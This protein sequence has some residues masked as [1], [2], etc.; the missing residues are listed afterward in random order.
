MDNK[1]AVYTICHNEEDNVLS[2]I[3][4]TKEADIVIV[5][6]TGST[7]NTVALLEEH[8]ITV[9]KITVSPW[10]FDEA[11]NQ[12]LKLLPKDITICIS[13]DFDERLSTGWRK[14]IE[15]VWRNE[16]TRLNYNYSET[17]TINS[18]RISTIISSRIHSR[19]N[20]QWV[21]PVHELL[22]YQGPDQEVMNYVSGLEIIHTPE[23]S[24]DRSQ[25]LHLMKLAVA[26]HPKDLRLVHQLGRD[27]MQYGWYDQCIETMKYNL[28]LEAVSNEQ[29]N[30]CRRLIARAYG[31][32]KQVEKAKKQLL[33]LIDE[34]PYCSSSYIEYAII[35]YQYQHWDDLIALSK[36]CS[37]ID[38]NYRS[39]YNEFKDSENVLYDLLSLAYYHRSDYH[40]ALAFE[41]KALSVNVNNDR[42][43]KNIKYYQDLLSNPQMTKTRKT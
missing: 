1:I 29:K 30:A 41:E 39:I 16:T 9:H 32:K 7:D 42:Y 11:R 17:L 3:D 24:K 21:Y 18:N 34:V 12:L 28:T 22:Y 36:Q 43:K 26:E 19:Q 40:Q 38:F 37:K 14:K 31:A 6:D 8:G 27:Y 10:R 33:K 13:L 15:Q 5:G 23:P 25:Y 2:W 20:Y 35:L 4:N